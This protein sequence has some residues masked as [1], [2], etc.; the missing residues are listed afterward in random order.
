MAGSRKWIT[1]DE[2]ADIYDSMADKALDVAANGGSSL[3]VSHVVE[4]LAKTDRLRARAADVRATER[5]SNS[6]G[7]RVA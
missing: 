3:D 6:L 4:N 2:I 1:R 5:L 7:N